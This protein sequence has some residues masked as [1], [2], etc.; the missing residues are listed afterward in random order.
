MTTL[1]LHSDTVRG[2]KSH[3]MANFYIMLLKWTS[4][5][6]LAVWLIMIKAELCMIINM[7]IKYM[8]MRVCSHLSLK[9]KNTFSRILKSKILKLCLFDV[10]F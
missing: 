6:I 2:A 3:Q 5:L 8:T 9:K 10:V 4:S 7:Y 1:V